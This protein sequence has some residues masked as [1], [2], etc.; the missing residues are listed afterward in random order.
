[1]P[2]LGV[3]S[4]QKTR[5]GFHESAAPCSIPNAGYGAKPKQKF[6]Y[7]TEAKNGRNKSELKVKNDK[8]KSIS[9]EKQQVSQKYNNL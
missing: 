8:N 2:D 3:A 1:M 9:F 7:R 6:Q 5:P 4:F